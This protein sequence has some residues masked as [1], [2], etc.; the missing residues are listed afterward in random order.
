MK[1]KDLSGQVPGGKRVKLAEALPL[2]TP[3]LLYIFPVYACN[4]KCRYC[5]FS[6]NPEKRGFISD[7]ILMD[8]DLYKRCIDEVAKFPNKLKVLRFV[9]MGEPLLHKNI[10][11]M[12]KYA[13]TKDVAG[14]VEIISNGSLLTPEISEALIDAG[15]SRL[16]VSLQGINSKKYQ[17]VSQI[18]I[19]FEK[20]VQNIKYYFEHKKENSHLYIKIMDTVLDGKDEEQKF[21]EIFGDI[22]DSMAIEHTVPIYPGVDYDKVLEGKD[23]SVTQFGLPVSEVKICPQPFFTFQI[24]PDGKVVPC[25]S[26]DYPEIIGD[27]NNESIYDIWNG[28][29]FRKFRSRMLDGAENVCKICSN[30][31]IIKYRMSPEDV[32]NEAVGRLKEI[33]KDK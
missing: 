30:C 24:N 8:F 13:I 5:I 9:G 10:A 4:F 2:D 25:F 31:N 18:N 11:E 26:L 14:V 32:L 22:C 27:C 1:A 23:L 17:E 3:F 20:F 29:K 7:K 6:V 28:E 19:D 21:Y 15:L 33:Y 12:V 16:I